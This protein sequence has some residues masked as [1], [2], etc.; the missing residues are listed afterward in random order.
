MRTKATTNTTTAPSGP[1]TNALVI[2]RSLPVTVSSQHESD[3]RL[4]QTKAN[5]RELGI[6]AKSD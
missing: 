5:K 4:L 1:N 2:E 3:L 6:F